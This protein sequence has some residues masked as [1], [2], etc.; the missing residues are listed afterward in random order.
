MS[1]CLA[2]VWGMINGMQILVHLPIL[3]VEFPAV[4]FLVVSQI[5]SVATF[6]IPYVNMD[7]MFGKFIKLSEDDGIFEDEDAIGRE[8]LVEALDQLG[9]SSR[10]LA[11]VMGSVYITIIVTIIA[12]F[13]ILIIYPLRYC[14]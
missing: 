5:V 2:Q 9:Y 4:S 8:N 11:R 3:N 13:L 14:G 7:D 6:D 1:G 10:Y 12:L